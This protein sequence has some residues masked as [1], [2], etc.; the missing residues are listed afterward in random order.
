VLVHTGSPAIFLLAKY[1]KKVTLNI[2]NEVIFEVFHLPDV[3][4][5]KIS[6]NLPNF[7]IWF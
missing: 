4:E 1:H 7:Y 3:R 2:Q 6:I 5:K